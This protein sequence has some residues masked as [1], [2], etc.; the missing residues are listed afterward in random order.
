M[1]ESAIDMAKRMVAVLNAY[2]DRAQTEVS[3]LSRW[4]SA[5]LVAVN[6][7]GA[8][9][10]ANAARNVEGLSLAGG[11][12]I[13]GLSLAI[14]SGWFNQ[15]LASVS[16]KPAAELSDYWSSALVAQERDPKLEKERGDK[17]NSLARWGWVGPTA[18]FVSYGLFLWGAYSLG[19]SVDAIRSGEL[20]T[21]QKLRA[22]LLTGSPSHTESQERFVALGCANRN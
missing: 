12:F 19:S 16:I 15:L 7:A 18:G 14:F 10:V 2:T 13:G 4:L 8:L 11:L 3:T 21:C 17:L 1:D 5:T 22:D 20:P 6:G 9:A